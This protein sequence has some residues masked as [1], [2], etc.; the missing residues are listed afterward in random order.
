V[1]RRAVRLENLGEAVRRLVGVGPLREE[2]D[3]DPVV[4]GVKGDGFGLGR[5]GLEV[6]LRVTHDPSALLDL[7][8]QSRRHAR[9]AKVGA[10]PETLDLGELELGIANLAKTDPPQRWPSLRATRKI[11]VGGSNSSRFICVSSSMA[12]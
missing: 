4:L 3:A 10:N 9:A 8:H 1:A 2:F 7:V 11:P 5:S 6:Q 12:P